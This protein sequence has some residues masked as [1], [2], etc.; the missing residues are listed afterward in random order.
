LEK[1]RD[2]IHYPEIKVKNYIGIS[3]DHSGSMRSIAHMAARDYNDNIAAITEESKK[4]GQDTIVSVVQCGVGH[5][6]K[7]VRESVNSSCNKLKP[8]GEYSYIADGGGTPL[9]DSVGELIEILE[10]APDAND[11]EVSFLVMVITDGQENNS[12]QWNVRQLTDKIRR[13]QATDKWTFAF[14]VP[15]GYATAL[16]HLGIPRGNILEWDQTEKGFALATAS[17]REA[18]TNYYTARSTGATAVKGF[19]Q[20]NLQGVSERTLNSKLVDISNEVQIFDVDYTDQIRP[21]VERKNGK[22]YVAGTA[23]Y[24]LTKKED[25]VQDYKVICI[26]DRQNGAVYSGVE[27]RNILGLPHHGTVKV[28]PGNHGKYDI[29]IQSTS[30]NRKVLPGT[31]VLVWSKAA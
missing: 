15:R 21:F 31:L 6:G 7:V 9:W 24:Q 14:R 12:K 13:L 22:S 8:I 23:F 17:T 11:P 5:S 27:A 10:R 28:A 3:R 26:R 16:E 20:T 19:Y 18:F 4:Q 1:H 29:F 30:I 25:E 2:T